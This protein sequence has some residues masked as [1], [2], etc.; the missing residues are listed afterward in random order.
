MLQT[1]QQTHFYNQIW[2]KKLF[3]KFNPDTCKNYL[4]H[5]EVYFETNR[6]TYSVEWPAYTK[7]L[8]MKVLADVTQISGEL[9]VHN[10]HQQVHQCTHHQSPYLLQLS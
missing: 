1:L 4:K 10:I 6:S 2:I 3:M 8:A 5:L 9:L 7:T